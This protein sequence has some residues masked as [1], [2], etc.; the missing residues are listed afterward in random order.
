MI[1]LAIERRWTAGEIAA[2]VHESDET[3]RRWIK[4]YRAEGIAGR[5]YG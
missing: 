5:S 4:R 2:V 1:L 3:V